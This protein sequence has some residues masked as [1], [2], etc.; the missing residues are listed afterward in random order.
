MAFCPDCS[1][2][3]GLPDF[4]KVCVDRVGVVGI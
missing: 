1:D 4:E 2:L 3:Q